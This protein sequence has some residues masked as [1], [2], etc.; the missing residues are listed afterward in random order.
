MAI[1]LQT[2]IKG[3][4]IL[5]PRVFLYGPAGVGKSTFASEAPNPLF[6]C[7]EDGVNNIDC[8]KQKVTSKTDI[9]DM[10]R[11][12][13]TDDHDYKTVVL[14][15]ADMADALITKEM[16]G[17]YTEGELGFGKDKAIYKGMWME[18]LEAF[19]HLQHKKNMLVILL[20][21]SEIVNYAPPDSPPY[22]IYQPN[23]SKVSNELIKH[24]AECTFFANHK[25]VLK[26]EKTG[27]QKRLV[28]ANATPKRFIYTQ[29]CASYFAKNRF[30]LPAEIEIKKG[31]SWDA[32][33]SAFIAATK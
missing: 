25:I 24:W 23:L 1:N 13:Y 17:S 15:T 8:A 7:A 26:E 20:G 16:R 21:H 19:E 9:L 18:V 27:F 6:L 31:E 5:P 11:A 32:F 22:D 14:D 4:N 30:D 33:M 2:V 28:G 12:L 3:K 29:P 10:C